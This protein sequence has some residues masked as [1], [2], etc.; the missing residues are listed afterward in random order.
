MAKGQ[1]KHF[2]RKSTSQLDIHVR[3]SEALD[4]SKR[5]MQHNQEL[6]EQQ[7]VLVFEP[8]SKRARAIRRS[9]REAEGRIG[10]IRAFFKFI[11]KTFTWPKKTTNS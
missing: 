4:I 11:K 9:T 5:L 1:D 3:L 7:K 2:I 10:W 6:V 8:W